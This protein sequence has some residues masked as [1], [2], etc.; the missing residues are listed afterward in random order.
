MFFMIFNAI[1]T[2][3]C[4]LGTYFNTRQLVWGFALWIF[5]N[6][7][8]ALMDIFMYKNY[9]RALLFL[10][11]TGMCI[12]GIWNWNKIEKERLNDSK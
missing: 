8:Y 11:Q 4:L 5:T 12:M 9:F 1:L 3:I 10:V 7:V 6:S 2:V